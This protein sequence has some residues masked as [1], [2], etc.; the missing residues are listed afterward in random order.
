MSAELRG[1][2]EKRTYISCIVTRED[3][4]SGQRAYERSLRATTMVTKSLSKLP[5]RKI[6]SCLGENE[7][8]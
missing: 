3:I 1:V 6:A 4:I 2:V 5:S 7:L 8:A